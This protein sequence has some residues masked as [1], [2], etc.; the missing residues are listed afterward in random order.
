MRT[1]AATWV[2]V[3]AGVALV[4]CTTV[5]PD[6]DFDVVREQVSQ[7]TG[8]QPQWNALRPED[9]Q[10]EDRTRELLARELTVDAAVELAL[11]NNRRLQAAYGELGVARADLVQAGL[12]VNPV[13]SADL[14]FGVNATATGV[15]IGLVQNFMRALQIPL[16]KR[17]AEAA[18]EEA[19][20]AVA[21]QVIDLVVEVK[22]A[23]L[24]VQ[25]QEQMVE[26]DR[27]VA[28]A[29]RLSAEFAQK[30]RTAGNITDLDLANEVALFEDARVKLA[31]DEAELAVVREDLTS[32][33]GLWGPRAAWTIGA[34][35]PDPPEEMPLAGLESLAVS[36]RLDLAAARQATEALSQGLGLTGLYGVLSDAEF[37]PEGE[38]DVDS[39]IWSVGPLFSIPIPIFDQGQATRASAL[40][41]LRQ[42][43]ERF[44][45][46]AVEI[47]S[48]VRRAHARL[49]AAR[50]LASHYR[51]VVLPLRARIVDQTQLQYNAMQLGLFQLLQAKQAQIDAGRAY[52]DVV[53]DYWLARADLEGAV[54]GALPDGG[55]TAAASATPAVIPVASDP[56]W[57]IAVVRAAPKYRTTDTAPPAHVHQGDHS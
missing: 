28:E 29:T 1:D 40:A 7:R 22:H 24:R 41:R 2:V 34:H 4:G 9:A 17:V 18:L 10:V 35:L 8:L 6:A 53:K 13:L 25:G 56:G 5:R 16:R 30:Q 14:T 31:A 38:R 21:S 51:R 27:S 54:G 12:L 32:L 44:T 55:P 43:E 11:L 42:S 15:A 48:Q 36:Q 50:E 39:G 19:K 49:Q 46:L 26:L 47:R 52:L 57:L 20:F 37:G 33:M 45:A 3:L 23:F